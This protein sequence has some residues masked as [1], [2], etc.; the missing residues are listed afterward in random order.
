MACNPYAS[1]L[2]HVIDWNQTQ[3]VRYAYLYPEWTRKHVI[4]SSKSKWTTQNHFYQCKI[5]SQGKFL[6]FLLILFSIW[7]NL[8]QFV[9]EGYWTWMQSTTYE[10]EVF[11]SGSNHCACLTCKYDRNCRV[12]FDIELAKYRC[13]VS[14][15]YHVDR[16]CWTDCNE[17]AVYIFSG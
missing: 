6:I 10:T 16:I 15:G 1:L 7:Q 9:D 2:L 8:H 3:Y 17:R 11:N 14:A 5:R 12:L 4:K 13:M